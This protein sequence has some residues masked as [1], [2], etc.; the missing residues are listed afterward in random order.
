[1]NKQL[2]SHL[3]IQAKSYADEY[4]PDAKSL[5]ET[6][7][8]RFADLIVNLAELAVLTVDTSHSSDAGHSIIEAYNNITNLFI[9]E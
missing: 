9:E 6:T 4:S 2:L 5:E 7:Y 3:W 1:M 8:L